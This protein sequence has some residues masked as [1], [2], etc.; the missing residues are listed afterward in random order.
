MVVTGRRLTRDGVLQVHRAP[1]VCIDRDGK[2][3]R[4]H[5]GAR[6]ATEQG[7][8]DQV[9]GARAFVPF[10][11]IVCGCVCRCVYLKLVHVCI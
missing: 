4:T 3:A 6:S 2:Q 10:T 7:S 8:D 9:K 1:R 5:H 11:V